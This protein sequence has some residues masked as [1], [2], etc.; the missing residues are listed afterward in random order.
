MDP[1]FKDSAR[2]S[3][4]KRLVC[5]TV[6]HSSFNGFMA[7]QTQLGRFQNGTHLFFLLFLWGCAAHGTKGPA[8]M[9]GFIGFSPTGTRRTHGH[10]ERLFVSTW[11]PSA[12]CSSGE[13]GQRR[14]SNKA[15]DQFQ[16]Q[17]QAYRCGQY[18][19]ASGPVCYKPS[20]RLIK[21]QSSR[22]TFVRFYFYFFILIFC[23]LPDCSRTRKNAAAL[24]LLP[25]PAVPPT[26]QG[27]A[28][29][30]HNITQTCMTATLFPGLMNLHWE[31]FCK[32]LRVQQ[33]N[34]T[35][36]LNSVA[37]RRSARCSAGLN[38]AANTCFIIASALHAY[39]FQSLI[40]IVFVYLW[41]CFIGFDKHR[42][43]YNKLTS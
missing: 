26:H 36:C 35:P 38:E 1:N 43:F 24:L 12:L 42:H 7:V 21:S 6:W 13:P 10:L 29:L 14:R 28:T 22:H 33:S 2:D 17:W 4:I 31:T 32:V 25:H 23:F 15:S 27:V 3:A 30:F 5:Y 16:T 11:E 20:A 39:T 37:A 40:S 18:Q 9:I 19:D 41:D 8:E 34:F